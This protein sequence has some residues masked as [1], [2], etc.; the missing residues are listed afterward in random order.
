MLPLPDW[1]DTSLATIPIGQG[2]AVTAVQ[3]IEAYNVIANGGVYVEPKL[4]MA[5]IDKTGKRHDTA[6]SASHRVISTQTA[7]EVRDMMEAVVK[8][9]TGKEAAIDGYNVAG[10]TGTARKP[11]PN[12][13]YT[14]AAGNY[15]YMATFAGFV[16]AEN[17]QLSAIVVLDEPT[18]TIFASGASAPVFGRV[19]AYGLRRFSIPPPGFELPS[20]VP[21]PKHAGAAIPPP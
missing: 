3:M 2:I 9:G 19:A 18:A 7:N 20:T 17:P 8:A 4:V 6:P 14:D 15:H 11:Q 13:G 1:S 16:P 21:P 5:S 12:G 10:K